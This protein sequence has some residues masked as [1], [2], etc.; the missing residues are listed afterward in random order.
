MTKVGC[1][2]CSILNDMYE[3]DLDKELQNYIAGL[4]TEIKVSDEIY[5]ERLSI[6]AACE[7][8]LK[9]MCRHCGCFVA[10]R[11]VKKGLSCPK[12]RDMQWSAV[13]DNGDID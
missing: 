11:A 3:R 2:W 4:D 1:K 12:P 5:E 13:E 9:G 6:C 7:S 8:N 10:A